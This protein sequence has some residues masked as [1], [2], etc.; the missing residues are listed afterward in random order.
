MRLKKAVE[1][2]LRDYPPLFRLASK[3]YHRSDNSFKTLSPGLP[4]ALETAFQKAIELNP[5]QAG[6][7]Y[8]FGLYRGY[9]L[10]K[11]QQICSQLGLRDTCFYGFDSFAGLPAVDGIDKSGNHFFEGQFACSQQEVVRHLDTHGVDWSKTVL[12]KGYFDKSLTRKLRRQYPFKKV[13]VALIDCDLYS[14]TRDVLAW[15]RDLFADGSI[16]LF[17][18]WYSYG[19]DPALGQQKALFEF[20][21]AN[22]DFDVEFLIDFLYHGKAFILHRRE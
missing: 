16:L 12:V 2:V 7:Y 17:D 14:S 4:Q 11:A 10:W 1:Y 9:A 6:D 8:E 18:D 19:D 3:L 21:D 22:R 13:A 20:L 5:G 15:S